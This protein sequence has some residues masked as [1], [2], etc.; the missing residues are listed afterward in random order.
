M[1]LVCPRDLV[2]VHVIE[3]PSDQI[4]LLFSINGDYLDIWECYRWNGREDVL[5]WVWLDMWP[6]TCKLQ[7]TLQHVGI[8][9]KGI[10]Y[11]EFI[12]AFDFN[13]ATLLH[14]AGM[15]TMRHESQILDGIPAGAALSQHDSHP[16]ASSFSSNRSLVLYLNYFFICI[17]K[18][19]CDVIEK[20]THSGIELVEKYVKFVKERTEI[21]QN[22]AKQ[23]RWALSFC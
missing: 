17:F 8:F 14:A 12:G 23:L 16:A 3:V 10:W 19:R 22:Y 2:G 21:E 1:I 15:S 20:H 7:P 11:K 9:R 4:W 5:E 13:N 18:D 6:R